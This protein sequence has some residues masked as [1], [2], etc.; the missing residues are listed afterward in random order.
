MNVKASMMGPREV[1]EL[2]IREHNACIVRPSDRAANGCRS[3]ETNTQNSSYKIFH[4]TQVGHFCRRFSCGLDMPCAPLSG[5]GNRLSLPTHI[6]SSKTRPRRSDPP[7]TVR[8][9]SKMQTRPTDT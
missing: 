6:P 2:G 3:L 8:E 5:V 1:P 9:A 7:L 4:L